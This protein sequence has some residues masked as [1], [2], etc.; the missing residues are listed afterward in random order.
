MKHCLHRLVLT[1][2]CA[3]GLLSIARAQ[4]RVGIAFEFD[5]TASYSVEAGQS[6]DQSLQRVSIDVMHAHP[7]LVQFL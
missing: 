2:L 6:L 7:A 1:A 3:V 5:S 4:G